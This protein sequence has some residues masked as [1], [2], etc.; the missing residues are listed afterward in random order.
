MLIIHFLECAQKVKV[1]KRKEYLYYPV[2]CVLNPTAHLLF[3]LS[4]TLL[5]LRRFK[6]FLYLFILVML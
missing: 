5:S 1:K 6:S 2:I 4:T 3:C